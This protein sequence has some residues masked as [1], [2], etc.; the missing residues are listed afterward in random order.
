VDRGVGRLYDILEE[1][2]CI[3]NTLVVFLSDNG[4]KIGAG[5]DNTPLV[6]G[7]GSVCEGGIRVPLLLHWPGKVPTGTK[8]EHPISALDLYPTLANLAGATIPPKKEI[9]GVDIWHAQLNNSSPRRN[10]P[11]FALRHWNGF[12]NVGI[13]IDNWKATRRG[14]KSAWQLFAIDKD[15]AEAEDLSGEHPDVL[16]SMITQAASW[17]ETH[18]RPLWFDNQN[19]EKSWD[20]KE[21]PVYD[22]TFRFMQHQEQDRNANDA[23]R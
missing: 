14:P 10:S 23:G 2:N 6:Q 15:V 8:F 13:R 9:D 3:D 20:E 18:T 4:G 17:S 16:Q 12:H 19:A 21:M 1:Q 5:A 22:S 11:I 7:K